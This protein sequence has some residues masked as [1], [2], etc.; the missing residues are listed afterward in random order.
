MSQQMFVLVITK[1]RLFVVVVVVVAFMHVDC[2][3]LSF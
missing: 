2:K 3:Y 1:I